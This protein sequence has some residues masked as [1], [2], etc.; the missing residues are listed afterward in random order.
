MKFFSLIALIAVTEAA[1]T[2][3]IWDEPSKDSFRKVSIQKRNS[4]RILWWNIDRG[5]TNQSLND[6]A[7]EKNLVELSASNRAPEILILGEYTEPQVMDLPLGEDKIDIYIPPAL[8]PSTRKQLRNSYGLPLKISYGIGYHFLIYSKIPLGKPV[9]KKLSWKPSDYY[10]EVLASEGWDSSEYSR[11]YVRIPFQVGKTIFHLGPLHLIQPWRQMMEVFEKRYPNFSFL[12]KLSVARE[13][14]FGKNS[15]LF[16]QVKSLFSQVRSD[17]YN[18]TDPKER[19]ILIGDFNIPKQIFGLQTATFSILKDPLIDSFKSDKSHTF[20]A[21]SAHES[22]IFPKMKLDHALVTPKV[23][24][25]LATVLHLKGS[26][27]YPIL[28]EVIE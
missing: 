28:L 7:L 25:S 12:S 17:Y 19:I 13:I 6:N 3:L 15:P 16:Y 24:I 8:S 11:N 23:N 26:D 5:W 4:V 14:I 1:P 21:S 18:K 22:R 9:S 2:K 27:H 10:A 20:P